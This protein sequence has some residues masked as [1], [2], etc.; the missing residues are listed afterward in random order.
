MKKRYLL[1]LLAVIAAA[2][3]LV[4][5]GTALAAE[6][7]ITVSLEQGQ[8]CNVDLESGVVNPSSGADFSVAYTWEQIDQ[9]WNFDWVLHWDPLPD[10]WYGSQL[11]AGG[12][13]SYE[14]ITSW[15][16]VTHMLFWP[17]TDWANRTMVVR[18]PEAHF[19]KVLFTPNENNVTIDY[20]LITP[21]AGTRT[22]FGFWQAQSLVSYWDLDAGTVSRDQTGAPNDLQVGDTNDGWFLEGVGGGSYARFYTG[23]STAVSYDTVTSRDLPNLAWVTAP[24]AAAYIYD[25]DLVVHTADG[26]YFKARLL[27]NGYSACLFYQELLP[28]DPSTMLTDLKGFIASPTAGAVDPQIGAALTAKAN[29]ALAALDKGK[30]RTA[31]NNLN[32]LLNQVKAQTGKKIS[33]AAADEISGQV[34]AIIAA[35]NAS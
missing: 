15:T 30:T 3:L 20:E 18:T 10:T 17:D 32:A 2:L 1:I 8:S 6:H 24:S 29:A 22:I 7:H 34:E 26:R 9:Y 14:D 16:L 21:D 4:L 5:P 11:G 12:Y 28:N 27:L 13:V 35:I 33:Q 19:Y 23:T 31:L 25:S